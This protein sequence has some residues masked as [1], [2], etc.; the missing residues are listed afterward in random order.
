MSTYDRRDPG[1]DPAYTDGLEPTRED[2][3][4]DLLEKADA[5]AYLLERMTADGGSAPKN[6]TLTRTARIIRGLANEI[7]RM[8]TDLAS[9]DVAQED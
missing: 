3:V 7:E 1:T 5:I 9:L 2:P 4:R 8:Q 6:K